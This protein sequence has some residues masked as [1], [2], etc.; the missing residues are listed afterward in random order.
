MILNWRT[1]KA[2]AKL[3]ARIVTRARRLRIVRD[4][5]PL[6]LNMDITA[7]HA[8]SCPLRL[9]ELLEGPDFDFSHDISGIQ[10]HINRKTGTL[11]DW[12]VPRYAK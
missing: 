11:E 1:T 9:R 7:T 4:H 3:I 6:A 12:F 8:N 10:F 2:D 5:D